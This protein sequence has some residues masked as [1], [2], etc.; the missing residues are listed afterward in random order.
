MASQLDFWN[1]RYGDAEVFAYGKEPNEFL[2]LCF[3]DG[4]A[5]P[6][7]SS[8]GG[9]RALCLCDGEGRNSVYL[10][11]THGYQCDAVDLSARGMEKLTQWASAEGISARVTATVGDVGAFVQGAEEGAY[12]LVISIFAHTPVALRQA[13]HDRVYQLLKPDGFFILEAYTVDN[14]GRNV[15]GPQGPETCMSA[16]TVAEELAGMALLRCVELE[17]TCCEG[18]YHKADRPAAVVQCLAAKKL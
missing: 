3:D 17:R 18:L 9:R 12:D 8:L 16:A 2:K 14:L 4:S 10:A 6:P 15:G 13:I 7:P 1:D 5:V 11:K